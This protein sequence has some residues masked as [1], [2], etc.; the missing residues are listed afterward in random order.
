MTQQRIQIVDTW[1]KEEEVG[2]GRE[3]EEM[4]KRNGDSSSNR[5]YRKERQA[6][7]TASRSLVAGAISRK[8]IFKAKP[9]AR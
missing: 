1:Q 2:N 3:G 8:I 5:I 9:A 7:I 6:K 4:A